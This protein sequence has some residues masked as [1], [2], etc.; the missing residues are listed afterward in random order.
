MLAPFNDIY[1]CMMDKMV[2]FLAPL[3][4]ECPSWV[5][6]LVECR[7]NKF[8]TVT[9]RESM[10]GLNLFHNLRI[11][12]LPPNFDMLLTYFHKLLHVVTIL[13]GDDSGSKD[14]FI[15]PITPN[16]WDTAYTD[17]MFCLR[18]TEFDLVTHLQE[19]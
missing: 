11:G 12:L 3:P 4:R 16:F 10:Q 19:G 18:V 2:R 13:H 5:V 14:V 1:H 9:I 6:I 17:S 15:G 8:A 7:V